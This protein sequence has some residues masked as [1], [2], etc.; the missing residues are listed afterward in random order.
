MTAPR[1]FLLVSRIGPDSLHPHWLG[2]GRDRGF[3]VLLSAYSPL[4]EPCTGTGVTFEY[5]SGAKVAGYAAVFD[6][7]RDVLARYDYVAIFDDD[8]LARPAGIKRLFQI[9]ADHDLKIAQ[10][11][12]TDDSHFT[13]ACLVRHPSFQLR[14]VNYIE[15]MCPV[16][17]TDILLEI[18][19]LFALGYESGIDLIWCNLTY[20]SPRDF[21]V[22]DAAPVRHTRRVGTS[23]ALNGFVDG[24]RY[25]D[26]IHA[27]L[28][29]FRLSWLP[30]VPYSAIRRDGATVKGRLAFALD[31]A[32][33]ALIAPRHPPLRDRSRN[34]AVYWKHLLIARARNLHAAWDTAEPPGPNGL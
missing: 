14:F 28:K 2:N 9:V 17:R 20:T 19:P 27:I 13:Y 24:R 31:A 3:D 22:I 32:R 8:L 5:R 11:A 15:M 4:V 29:R 12:L 21:A 26:D 7:H 34:I 23:K 33:L 30:C 6:A 16:F 1:R 25:E 10:P 18:L